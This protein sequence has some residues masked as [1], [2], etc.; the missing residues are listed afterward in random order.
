MNGSLSPRNSLPPVVK[1]LL[2]ISV[3]SWLLVIFLKEAFQFNA[4][5]YFALYSWESSYFRPWQLFTYL[6]LH[7]DSGIFHLFFNMLGLWMFGSVLERF[8]G[9]KRFLAYFLITGMGA[10]IIHLTISNIQLHPMHSAA[11]AYLEGPNYAAFDNFTAKYLPNSYSNETLNK[12]KVEW[13]YHPEDRRLISESQLMVQ[14]IKEIRSNTPSVG[15]SGAL[16]GLLLAFGMLFPN[17]MVMMLIPPIPMKAKYFVF[18]FGGLELFMGIQNNINDN[19]AHFAHLGGMVFGIILI[20]FWR[21]QD[22]NRNVYM[23]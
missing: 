21:K 7:D 17:A 13:Y 8:W 12:F 9:A 20:L 4:I 14:E 22:K 6:F 2:I 15:S 18:I 16:Y 3:V 10:G 11:E 19:V 5:K 1:S 23:P